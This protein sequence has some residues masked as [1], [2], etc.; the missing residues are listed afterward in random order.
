MNNI[1]YRIVC[2]LILKYV[3]ALTAVCINCSKSFFKCFTSEKVSTSLVLYQHIQLFQLFFWCQHCHDCDVVKQNIKCPINMKDSS[4]Y[5]E[6]IFHSFFYVIKVRFQLF[7]EYYYC[8]G[9]V[10]IPL[11]VMLKLSGLSIHILIS[12][13]QYMHTWH[14]KSGF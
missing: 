13:L 1:C 4:T 14:H 3:T 10:K 12:W 6:S 2:F 8:I 11:P 5:W 9:I 7:F